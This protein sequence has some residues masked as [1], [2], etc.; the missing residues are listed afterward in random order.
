MVMI[1]LTPGSLLIAPPT[2]PDQRFESAVLL[3]AHNE[4][5]GSLAFCLN[6]VSEY[7][8]KDLLPNEDFELNFPLYWGGPVGKST[9][10]ML[11][12]KEWETEN[13]LDINDEWSM[14]STIEMFNELAEG[15]CPQQFRLFYGYCSWNSGQLESE[16]QGERPWNH[17]HSWLIAE[18]P[19]I[20]WTMEQPVEDLWTSATG[21]SAHQAVQ[22]WL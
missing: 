11:H 21:M 13:T 4:T 2:I 15:N 20:E 22:N 16:I 9:V 5:E 10:W 19:G 6:K 14:S 7:T 17:S 8:V 3:L 18:N 1:N 12:S